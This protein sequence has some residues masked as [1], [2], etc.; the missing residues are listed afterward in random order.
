MDSSVP[1]FDLTKGTGND[2]NFRFDS[3]DGIDIKTDKFKLDTDRLDIDSSTRI[4]VY[5]IY[6]VMKL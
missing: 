1:K 2:N 6:K 4:T 3:S 5:L